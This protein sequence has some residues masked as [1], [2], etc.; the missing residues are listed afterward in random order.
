[1]N[2]DMSKAEHIDEAKLISL[3]DFIV[4]LWRTRWIVFVVTLLNIAC[5]VTWS[6]Y[7]ARYA[8]NGFFQF[9]GA[10][11]ILAAKSKE[12]EKEKEPGPG[13]ALSDF[14]RYAA[15]F[16]TGER[17]N[18]YLNDRKL[19]SV[20]G[21]DDLQKVFISRDGL[22]RIVEPIYPFTKV[23]AKE[24]MEQPKDSSNNVIGLRISYEGKTPQIAQ[25]NVG[26]LGR[27]A[28]DSII[29]QTYS[30]TLRFKHEEI[31]TKLVR[32]DNT[33]IASKTQLEEYRRKTAEL[34]QIISR[35]P[36]GEG[37]GSRQV[38]TVTE[39]NARYLPP[40]TQLMT[41][42]VQISETNEAILK[43][44]REQ[45]QNTLLL[46]YYGRARQLL[47]STKSGEAV[48][49]GLEPV[50][51]AIFKDK[52]L[53]D[54]VVKEAYNMITVDNQNAANVYLDKS[55]FIAG[56]TL[57]NQSTAR[58]ALALVISM[59]VGLALS[60]MLIFVRTLTY[61]GNRATPQ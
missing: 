22:S 1:M 15:S 13:I 42:E 6:L 59:L 61:S 11:P 36:S 53:D 46:E 50:K 8:S 10:I 12:K 32:L 45:E 28:M 5:G 31:R 30:D 24:L 26:L 23:D 54:D 3:K 44:K 48:L 51:I 43:A 27:Y 57:P 58:P 2:K 18:E 17:F 52:N 7:S 20:P 21:I 41:T 47:D 16:G 19:A 39:D 56:P 14:K 4:A 38:V 9:G 49:R 60:L 55:R 40:A 34:K 37:Q 33:I 25:Q 29:Y 35:N